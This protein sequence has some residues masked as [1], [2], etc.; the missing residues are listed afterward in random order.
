MGFPSEPAAEPALDLVASVVAPERLAVDDEERRAEDALRDRVVAR[1]LEAALPARLGPDPLG[2]RRVEAELAREDLEVLDVREVDGAAREVGAQAMARP[3]RGA[4]GIALLEPPED[5][6]RVLRRDRKLSRQ[7]ERH[8]GETRRAL[9]VVQRVLALDRVADRA[10]QLCR[11]ERDAKQDR[12]PA[13]RA[14]VARGER[15]D[16]FRGDVRIW[17]REVDV[18]IDRRRAHRDS[19]LQREPGPA[20]ARGPLMRPAWRRDR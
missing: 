5:A 16:P 7:G 4:L 20:V 1:R 12:V 19:L 15:L 3:V 9:E 14:A 2:L 10:L 13:H 18:E 17:R 11:L 6:R 8:A